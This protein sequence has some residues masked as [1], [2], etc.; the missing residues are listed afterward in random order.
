MGDK[1][2]N[3]NLYELLERKAEAARVQ[4][5]SEEMALHD[6]VTRLNWARKKG[7]E[8]GFAIGFEEGLAEVEAEGFAIGF[9]ETGVEIARKMLNAGMDAALVAKYTKLTDA[10]IE[11]LIAEQMR[12]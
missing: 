12:E 7:F 5:L 11:G 1:N 6:E 4:R 10:Q 8:Q 3:I 2:E 9:A